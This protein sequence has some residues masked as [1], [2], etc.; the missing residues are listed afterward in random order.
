M[1]DS[2]LSSVLHV[3]LHLA[4]TDAPLTSD[5]LARMLGTN[6][7]VVRKTLA[8][9]RDAGFVV[10]GKGHGGGWAIAVDL[11]RVTLRDVYEAVG[12]PTVFAM[13]HR[14]EH[15]ACLVEQAVNAALDDTLAAARALIDQR[16]GAITLADL[17]ADFNRRLRAHP[18]HDRLHAHL[19]P[20]HDPQHHEH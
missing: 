3:L 4:H 7:V 5:Q 9:L 14:S 18:P 6:P 10:A 15:P 1:K 13:G 12:A 11:R 8:G 19:H 20:H 16:L 17:S 2:K